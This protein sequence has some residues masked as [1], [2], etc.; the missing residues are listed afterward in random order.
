MPQHFLIWVKVEETSSSALKRKGVSGCTVT[1][2][3]LRTTVLSDPQRLLWAALAC[4][5]W[6]AHGSGV[7]WP[8]AEHPE[9]HLMGGTVSLLS[10]KIAWVRSKGTVQAVLYQTYFIALDFLQPTSFIALSGRRQSLTKRLRVCPSLKCMMVGMS[11]TTS[12]LSPIV[13]F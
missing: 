10:Q 5:C 6:T 3:T 7:A 12:L 8:L 1:H 2:R 13:S 9:L 11:L 4:I